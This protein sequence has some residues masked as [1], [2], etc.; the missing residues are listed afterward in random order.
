LSSQL[1]YQN[2]QLKSGADLSNGKPIMD[3]SV[4]IM[5]DIGLS[6]DFDATQRLGKNGSFQD[7]SLGAEYALSLVDWMD[8]NIGLSHYFYNNDTINILSASKNSLNL[9][10]DF[11]FNK[12]IFDISYEHYFGTDKINNLSLTCLYIY[13]VGNFKFV[14]LG[15]L[16]YSSYTVDKKRT[17]QKNITKNKTVTQNGISSIFISIPIYYYVLGGFSI[18]ASPSYNLT[19]LGTISLNKNQF[20]FK[21]G[22]DYSLDF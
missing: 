11:M 7:W 12:L 22:L 20:L 5:H 3:F 8:F 2:K 21:I 1:V 10:A 13:K 6:L 9:S 4:G 16:T 19:P 15:G 17:N 18:Y 14:P